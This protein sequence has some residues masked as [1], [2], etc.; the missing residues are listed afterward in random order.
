MSA[1]KQ[2]RSFS[3][4]ERSVPLGQAVQEA[5][6][7]KAEKQKQTVIAGQLPDHDR[8]MIIIPD[9]PVAWAFGQRGLI[10]RSVMSLVG[11]DGIGKT[12]TAFNIIGWG[13]RRGS[14]GVY[15]E[16]EGK[17]LLPERILRCLHTDRDIADRMY[18]N[19]SFAQAFSIKEAVQRLEERVR[20][21]RDPRETKCYTPVD[22]P[23]VAV[24]DSISKLAPPKEAAGRAEYGFK[25]LSEEETKKAKK[26]RKKLEEAQELDEGSNMEMAKVLQKWMRN[27]PAFISYYNVLLILIEHQNQAV[28]IASGGNFHKPQD[29][30]N[31]TKIG[32]NAVNQNA[33]YQVVL[34]M[35]KQDSVDSGKGTTLMGRFCRWR[36][37]KSTFGPIG[38]SFQYRVCFQHTQDTDTYQEQALDFNVDLG[39]ILK[40]SNAADVVAQPGGLWSCKQLGVNNVTTHQLNQALQTNTALLEAAQK[41]LQLSG[42]GKG[43][44]VRT[45]EATLQPVPELVSAAPEEEEVVVPVIAAAPVTEA[46]AL[47]AKTPA[48]PPAT[49]P[50]APTESKKTRGRPPKKKK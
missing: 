38:R 13:A 2:R 15:V 17:P 37:I 50:T 45:L 19:T 36:V 7:E 12:S 48:P 40:R 42:L 49:V 27:C 23:I 6:A 47:T 31:R 4:L 14:P 10:S 11:G 20:M 25:E 35:G 24:I 46:K 18:Q 26:E 5:L 41:G 43:Y 8:N 30:D 9:L 3:L 39:H 16:T 44:K 33:A 29:L 22:I 28:Q 34:S 1:P 21:I 32:G